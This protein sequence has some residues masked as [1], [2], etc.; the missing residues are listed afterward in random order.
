MTSTMRST[1]QRVALSSGGCLIPSDRV[2][3]KD[4]HV[5]FMK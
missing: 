5:T 4:H 1:P 2:G 3:E